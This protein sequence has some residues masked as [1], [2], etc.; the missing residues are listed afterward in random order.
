MRGEI[1]HL[2]DAWQSVLQRRSYPPPIQR[3]LGEAMTAT[4]LLYATI[5]FNGL[6]TLQLQGQGPLNLL[7][8]HCTG[9]G[10]LRGLARWQG[11]VTERPLSDLCHQGTLVI[12]IDPG[13]GRERYQGIVMV[14]GDSLAAALE[15]YFERSEQLPT[16]FHLAANDT[17][18]A[19]MLLQRMPGPGN[20]DSDGW[21]R[22]ERLGATLTREELLALDTKTLL[23][24]LFH[25]EE[26]RLFKPQPIRFACTCS[27]ERTAAML[28][29]LGYD[30]VQ[31]VL[32]D[33]KQVEVACEFCG[34]NYCF[35]AVDAEAVFAASIQPD[36]P[37]THH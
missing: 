1:A 13:E 24:R 21:N 28:L 5:K 12:T 2:T 11:E 17:R 29:S 36:V 18:A 4:A 7:L 19:G 16:R 6:L 26:V 35:D 37:A 15:Q 3:L 30:E 23:R 9:D 34:M 33:K 27:R 25:Q 14:E 31:A 32:Q 20:E 10:S 8:V 22:V